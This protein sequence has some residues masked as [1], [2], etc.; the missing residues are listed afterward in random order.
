MPS[1][2][3]KYT[4]RSPTID[5]NVCFAME[6]SKVKKIEDL[7]QHEVIVGSVGTAAGSYNYPKALEFSVVNARRSVENFR[8]LAGEYGPKSCVWRYELGKDICLSGF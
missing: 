7:M 6:R 1:A 8:R 2:P 4:R 3:A 5:T